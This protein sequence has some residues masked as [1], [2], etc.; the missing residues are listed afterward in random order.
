MPEQVQYR[1]RQG[2]KYAGRWFKAGE[3]WEPAGNKNDALIIRNR[4]VATERL[5]AP[6]AVP[7][8]KRTSKAADDAA[9]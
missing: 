8:P 4:L 3:L 9:K 1:V 2:F 5:T 6:K 7:V